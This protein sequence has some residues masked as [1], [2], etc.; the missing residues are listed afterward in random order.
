MTEQV[1]LVTGSARG[2]GRAIAL[3]LARDGF[4]V[5]VNDRTIGSEGEAVVEEIRQQGGT[6]IAVGADISRSEEVKQLLT[7]VRDNFGR[8]D[9]LVNNAGIARDNLLMRISDDEWAET[10]AVNLT[11]T[12]YCTREAI[13]Y[14]MRQRYGRIISMASVVG[15]YGNAGQ[16]HYAA[17]KAGVIAFTRSVAKEYGARGITANAV[18]PGYIETPMTAD[19]SDQAREALT[20][21]IPVGRPGSPEE[22]AA[23]VAFLA[24]PDAAYVNGQVI[25]VDGGM[26]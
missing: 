16:A 18:A 5:V 6:A 19:F 24:S 23:V 4:Q 11:G 7:A 12:F 22:V 13:R 2:I 3:R 25:S 9:V 1:A 14:M 8:L 17:S 15:L 10:I 20:R 21:R 26:N